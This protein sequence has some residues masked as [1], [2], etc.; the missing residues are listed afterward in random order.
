MKRLS[1]QQHKHMQDLCQS[2]PCTADHMQ[3]QSKSSHATEVSQSSYGR[4]CNQKNKVAYT[5]RR[6]TVGGVVE[7]SAMHSEVTMRLQK[8]KGGTVRI[9]ICLLF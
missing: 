7:R 9:C 5:D 2:M 4:L 3:S 8:G 6:L 1:T